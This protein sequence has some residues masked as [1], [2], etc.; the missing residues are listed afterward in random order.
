MKKDFSKGPVWKCILNQAIPLTVAQFVQLLYNIVDRIYIGHLAEGDSLALTG[1]GL[2]F[3]VI[4]II[5]AFTALFGIGGVPLFSIAL[6]EEN[7]EKAGKILGNSAALLLLSSVILTILCYTLCKP[8]LFA[9]GASRDSVVYAD[10]YLKVYLAGTVFSMLGTGLNGYISAQGFP[11]IGMMS[12]VLGALVNI[13]LDPVFIFVFDM[14]ISGAALATVISQ[15][16]SVIWVLKFLSGKKAFILLERSYMKIE[17][18]ITKEISKLGTANFIMQ[19]TAFAVQV[20]CNNTL[21][22]F[23]GDVYVGIMTVLS[24]VRDMFIMPL[25]GVVNGSQAVIGYNYGAKL[26]NRVKA[27]INFNTYVGFIYS[28][29]AWLLV[30]IFPEFFLKLFS[31]DVLMVETGVQA[32]HLYFFGF[33]F[34]AFQYAGQSTFQSLGDAKHA[35][36]FSL[37]RKVILVV[38]LTL[39][40]PYIGFGVNGV[41]LAEPI[42]NVIGGGACY[43]TMRLTVY[44]KLET[45]EH[46]GEV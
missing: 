10:A 8:M 26:Y 40:L 3:P 39:I 16:V 13:I 14:G 27:G 15:F 1:V 44:K 36:T 34:M 25:F 32:M 20:T 30:V 46:Y 37:L 43:L 19:G 33:V 9:F 7:K 35:I 45:E 38:P 23:G 42:S 41:F 18:Q 5:M 17:K 24:S 22:N 29:L 11:G 12:V 21:Q 6:G 4:T 2:T 31:S 28:A